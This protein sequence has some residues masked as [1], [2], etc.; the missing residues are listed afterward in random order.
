MKLEISNFHKGEVLDILMQEAIT[1]EKENEYLI[2]KSAELLERE[3][4]ILMAY[5]R[6]K[7][8]ENIIEE[9]FKAIGEL[10]NVIKNAE[11]VKENNYYEVL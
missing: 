8:P 3:K 11:G 6:I 10:E 4:S 1:L 9:Y 2:K 5:A 7:N